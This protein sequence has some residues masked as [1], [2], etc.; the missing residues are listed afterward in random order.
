MSRFQKIA[1]RLD[2]Y[3]LDALLL[4]SEPNRF[5]ASGFRSSSG[6]VLVTGAESYFFTDSRYIEADRKSVV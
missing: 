6:A 5:Y 1:E 4:L 3:G 2:S